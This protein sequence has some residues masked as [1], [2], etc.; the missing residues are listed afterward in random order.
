MAGRWDTKMK[1]GT[2]IKLPTKNYI[3]DLINFMKY[4]MKLILK[5]IEYLIID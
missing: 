1:N 4:E 2:I 3:K 5:N